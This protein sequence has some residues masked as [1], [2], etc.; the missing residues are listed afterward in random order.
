MSMR[1]ARMPDSARA[2]M[3]SSSRTIFFSVS[4]SASVSGAG[5][6]D[7]F[8]KPKVWGVC[9]ACGGTEFSRRKD[10]NRET[11]ENRLINYRLLTY[12][13]IPFF[14]SRGLLKTVDGTGTIEA[15]SRKIA[16][17]LKLEE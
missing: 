14:E 8:Q 7:K 16:N 12:P 4:R 2:A 10:D 5:Y 3:I 15:V 13:T 11:V 9:D 17:V 6:H 1:S